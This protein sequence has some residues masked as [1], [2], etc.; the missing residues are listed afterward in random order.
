MIDGD[1]ALGAPAALKALP[2]ASFTGLWPVAFGCPQC[3]HGSWRRVLSRA[4]I[5]LTNRLFDFVLTGAT[6]LRRAFVDA[7]RATV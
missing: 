2:N 7:G 6:I 3:R 1:I 4:I 5:T